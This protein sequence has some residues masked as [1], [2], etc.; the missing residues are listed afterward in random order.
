M[1]KSEIVKERFEID[2]E[3]FRNQMAEMKPFRLCMDMISNC[4]DEDSIHTIKFSTKPISNSKNWKITIKDDGSGFI[5]TS[6]SYTL[7]GHSYK[8]DD[9]TKIGRFNLGEKQFFAVA[10]KGECITRDLH[11]KFYDNVRKM[12]KLKSPIEGTI[13]FGEFNFTKDEIKDINQTMKKLIVPQDKVLFINGEKVLPPTEKIR[14]IRGKLR[15]VVENEKKRLVQILRETDVDLYPKPEGQYSWLYELGVPVVRL[16]D[17]KLNWLI[18]IRQKIPQ[19]HSRKVV[20][21]PY[22][23][24]LYALV[25]EKTVDLIEDEDAGASWIQSGMKKADA[26]TAKTILIKQFGTSKVYI[27]SDDHMANEE[28]L[29][30]GGELLRSSMYDGETRERLQDLGLIKR[31][32]EEFGKGTEV[33]QDVEPTIEMVWFSKV[34]KKIALDVIEVENLPVHFV[35]TKR[36]NMVAWFEDTFGPHLTFNTSKL[37]KDFFKDFNEE[38]IKLIIHELAHYK[39]GVVNGLAHYTGQYVDELGRI[40]SVIGLR[41][42]Q[43]W[44]H[45]VNDK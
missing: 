15:T 3:G 16:Q 36:I 7:Y 5:K 21:Q 43:Y 35:K 26:E 37:P 10:I 25:L 42:I 30:H 6:D 9:P 27:Q 18:D 20:S 22:L 17:R 14:T 31:A 24:D 4:F 33:P 12:I 2:T 8:R 45:M 11:V 29:E 19:E 23:R 44:V 40:G 41:G 28:V 32:S 13:A 1:K 34:V 38:Q 39:G